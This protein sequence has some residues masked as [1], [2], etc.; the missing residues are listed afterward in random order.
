MP[1][2]SDNKSRNC[3]PI[4]LEKFF[5]TSGR[6]LESSRNVLDVGEE[7]SISFESG[8]WRKEDEDLHSKNIKQ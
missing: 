1:W 2:S 6:G 8:N 4:F 3:F 5:T 7:I